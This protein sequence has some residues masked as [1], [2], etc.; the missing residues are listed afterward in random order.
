MVRSILAVLLGWAAVGVLVVST[1]MALMRLYPDQYVQGK[2]P[3]D[4]LAA[5]SLATS[6]LWSVIGGYITARLAP[7]K[8]WHHILSLVIWGELMGIASSTPRGGRSRCGTRSG[9]LLGAGC[10]FGGWLRAEAGPRAN[11]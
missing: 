10:R 11:S 6:T 5:I 1:D 7:R 3:P 8:P 2:L 4:Y 9:L